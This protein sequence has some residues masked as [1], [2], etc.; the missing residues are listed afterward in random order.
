MVER[1][2]MTKALKNGKPENAA[3]SDREPGECCPRE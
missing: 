3:S 2:A 1:N